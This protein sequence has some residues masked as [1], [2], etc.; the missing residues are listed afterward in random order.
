VPDYD[1]QDQGSEFDDHCDEG[2]SALKLRGGAA[3][4]DEIDEEQEQLQDSTL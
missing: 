4:F 2:L 1:H 3:K